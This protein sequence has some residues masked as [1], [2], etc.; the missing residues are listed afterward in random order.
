M[1]RR[2]A[3]Q[4]R[5]ALDDV[6][7]VHLRLRRVDL[8][9]A[10]EL[11]HEPQARGEPRDEVGLEAQDHVGTVEAVLRLERLAEREQRARAR[12]VASRRL[13]AQPLRRR[14]GREHGLHLR[15]EGRRGAAAGQEA[16]PCPALPLLLGERLA[17]RRAEVAPGPLLPQVQHGL[18]TVGVVEAEHVRLSE[19]VGASQARRVVGVAFDLGRPPLVALD[20]D[21][22]RVA[23]VAGRRREEER[24]ARDELLR[25]PH[26]RQDLLLGLLGAGRETG[27]RE[28]S[29]HQGHELAA[30]LGVLEHRGLLGELA[31]QELEERG[32]VGELVE[33]LPEAPLPASGAADA[34][35]AHGRCGEVLVAHRWHVEQVTCVFTPYSSFSFRP[36]SSW[37]AGGCQAVL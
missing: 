17:Q 5:R 23:V 1:V 16:Q 18:R 31:V 20:Q 34:F 35:E 21:A 32:R 7:A 27:E 4:R 24:A 30:A 9:P 6:D 13:P 10:G 3:A 11:A 29:P 14:E 37:F 36:S 25:L 19:D 12:V 22:A 8:A 15:R 2:G 33:A 26:V 28:R